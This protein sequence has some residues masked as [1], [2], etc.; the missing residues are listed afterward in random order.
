[1]ADG[2]LSPSPENVGPTGRDLHLD[3]Q[4]RWRNG[5]R[6]LVEDYLRRVPHLAQDPEA[7][8]DLLCDEV[9]LR[10]ERGESPRLE[11]YLERFP[12]FAGQLRAQWEV[13]RLFREG[14][15]ATPSGA[16][17]VEQPP[18]GATP[19]T[20][21][22][23][24]EILGELGRGGMAVVYQARQLS[25][26]RSV[27]L[28]MVL[29]G[30][31]ASAEQRDRFRAE[32]E[33]VARLRHPNIVQVHEVG[34]HD[35][36]PFLVLEYADG[37]SLAARL[38][39]TPLPPRPAAALTAVLAQAV[40]HAHQNGIVHRD[41][42]PANVLLQKTEDRSQETEGK[43]GAPPPSDSCLL[44]AVFSPKIA[45]F[46]LAKRLD[47]GEERTASGALIGTPSYM[48]PEQ[49]GGAMG[50]RNVADRI[51]PTTDVYALGAIL[52][53]LLTG[54]PPFRAASPLETV[55]HVLHD[56]PVPPRRSQP[57]TPRDLETVCLKCLQKAPALRYASAAALA[58]DLGL[59][60]AGR[61]V[62]ARRVGLAGRAGRWCR[63][64]PAVA[65]LL[66]LAAALLL[67]LAVRSS[68][69]LGRGLGQ[70][71]EP[72]WV[73]AAR[74]R[75]V[76]TAQAGANRTSRRPGQRFGTLRTIAQAVEL[77]GPS[78]ELRT[79]A[80]AALSLPDL[81]PVKEWDGWQSGS[82]FVSFDAT[83]ERY[84]R[85]DHDGNVS[86][87]RVADDV[88]VAR[89]PG[90]GRPAWNGVALSPD[91][92]L[93][94][95]HGQPE[96]QRAGRVKLWRLD[97]SEPPLVPEELAA[98]DR[99]L[100]AGDRQAAIAFRPDGR[101]VAVAQPRIA[102]TVFDTA[103]GRRLH[104]LAFPGAA[105]RLAFHPNL[106]RLAA[107]GAR[108]LKVLDVATSRELADLPPL[109][110]PVQ[111]LAWHPG[112][113]LL[114]V[115]CEDLRIYLW[116]VG[117]RRT[118]V[119]LEG[120]NHPALALAFHPGGRLLMS[121]DATAIMRLWEVSSG[122]QL[123]TVPGI[124]GGFS[125]DDRPRAA[126]IQPGPG[127]LGLY[128]V[129]AGEEYRS[130]LPPSP[131]GQGRFTWASRTLG[132]HGPYQAMTSDDGVYLLD[133]VSGQIVGCLP[134]PET[135]GLLFEPSGALLTYGRAGVQRWPVGPGT[136]ARPGWL[137]IGPPQYL[138][139]VTAAGQ[140]GA[141]AA[142]RVLALPDND[143]GAVVHFQD[144]DRVLKLGPQRS[145]ACCA[146]SPDG[147]W[148]A[149][150]S[151]RAPGGVGAKVWDARSGRL[152]KDFAVSDGCGVLFSPDGKWLATTGGGC[153]L[154]EV[155][156]WEPGPCLGGECVAFSED[157]TLAAVTA[158]FGA[159]RLVAPATGREYARL[160]VPEPIQLLPVTFTPDGGHLLAY[161]GQRGTLHIWD[162]RVI[163]RQLTELGL[164]WEP[165]P[166]P[167]ATTR[168]E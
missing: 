9:V 48:A 63:R 102:I 144:S 73:K 127:K 147:R 88:E 56:E 143:G 64:N 165:S 128:D 27:A 115:A 91:G 22:P 57:A 1:M 160:E 96:G 79:E 4:R 81:E 37:G 47:D 3:Q 149:T 97:G 167:P 16:P 44:T 28:K 110:A 41:L 146:V 90:F 98:G 25:L 84:A 82:S 65:S 132:P 159:L 153:R 42:K 111:A 138:F 24:Y 72:E 166:I 145:V 131:R 156:T 11:E 113:Q 163:R 141:S 117:T 71:Q 108:T 50:E 32:A 137:N 5:E 118:A 21:P 55:R 75:D 155:D 33:A 23:G 150:G 121:S 168:P 129:A 38:R 89:L 101:Q 10:E 136:A 18:A 15:L 122:R 31:H 45:D 68:A 125:H 106:P 130:V 93:V 87:R 85:Q 30:R 95:Q 152:V 105:T 151:L 134:A 8:L 54:R 70:V 12:Q 126:L 2:N 59:F 58:D 119:F 26:N 123:L 43:A 142:G 7:I 139:A 83:L 112:G 133:P 107:A 116:D 62:R 53:E 109:P 135:H 46:G 94:A 77:G 14:S 39:G 20:S 140:P 80:I 162:L 99:N 34:E 124:V 60:L 13:H 104:T 74:Q 40:H 61:P 154:W 66:G 19:A 76:L 161:G 52:Y 92:R 67:A 35:G 6:A 100:E 157:G 103:T 49:C 29:A 78:P 86:V 158:E 148:V 36:L 164:D 69:D 120:H 114:A 51:G 17:T